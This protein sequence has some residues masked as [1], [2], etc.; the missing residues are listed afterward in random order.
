[1]GGL[2][3]EVAESIFSKKP[4][5]IH[6]FGTTSSTVEDESGFPRE[7]SFTRPTNVPIYVNVTVKAKTP[8]SSTLADDITNSIIEYSQGLLFS[9]RGYGVADN[10][11]VSQINTP[12]NRVDGV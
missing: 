8:I 2:D 5:G 4:V 9:D 12:I 10:V 11:P 1:M 3:S 7:I 6:A